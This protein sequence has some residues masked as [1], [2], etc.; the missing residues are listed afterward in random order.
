MKTFSVIAWFVAL[1]LG[2]AGLASAELYVI[3]NKATPIT[4]DEIKDVFL[5]EKQFSGS[6]RLVPVDNAAVQEEFIGK[7]LKMDITKYNSIWMKKSFREGINPPAGRSGDVEVM[8][9]VRRTPGAIGY[10]KSAPKG[11]AVITS[12]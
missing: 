11:V 5:G 7:A 10:V 12:Y 8:E 4:A 1:L 3:A 9:F 6:V 2:S